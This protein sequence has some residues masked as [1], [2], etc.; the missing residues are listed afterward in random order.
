MTE[1]RLAELEALAKAATPGPNTVSGP[2]EDDD[3][4]VWFGPIN[5]GWAKHDSSMMNLA[6]ARYTAAARDAVP[7]MITALRAR[8]ARIA[9]LEGKR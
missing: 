4:F 1:E 6:D 5:D 9:E 2:G 7:E 8:D 3:Y